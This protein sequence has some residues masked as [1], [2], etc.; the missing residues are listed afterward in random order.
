MAAADIVKYIT[1]GFN[2][3]EISIV[4]FLDLSKTFDTVNHYIFFT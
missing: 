4:V 3:K 1:N 2:N